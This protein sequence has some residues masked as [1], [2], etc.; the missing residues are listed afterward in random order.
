MD[1]HYIHIYSDAQYILTNIQTH[2]TYIMC[3]QTRNATI[4][5]IISY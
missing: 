3:T 1:T 4:S 5:P 2:N